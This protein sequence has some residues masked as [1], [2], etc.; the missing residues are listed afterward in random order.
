MPSNI[1]EFPNASADAPDAPDAGEAP[2]NQALID[3]LERSLAKAKNGEL[4][5]AAIV[6]VYGEGRVTT[7]WEHN[8]QGH[9]L[10]A[11]CAYLQYDLIA[12]RNS[13]S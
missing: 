6:S 7:Q 12:A 10:V 13:E 4:K 9:E 2:V 11:G 1:I 8:G 3:M 5:A